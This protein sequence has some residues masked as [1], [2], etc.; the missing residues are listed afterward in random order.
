MEVHGGQRDHH[1]GEAD[2]RTDRQIEFAGNHQQARTDRDQAEIRSHLRPVHHAVEVEHAGVAGRNSKHEEHHH[3][4]GE[5][6]EFRT[7]QQMPEPRFL[8]HTFIGRCGRT[9][10]R[11]R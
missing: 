7:V 6:G 2:H 5:G 9:A 1:A 11:R 10:G 3:G 8:A 4:A